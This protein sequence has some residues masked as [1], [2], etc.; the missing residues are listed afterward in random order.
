MHNAITQ[1][2][3]SLPKT[4]RPSQPSTERARVGPHLPERLRRAGRGPRPRALD[5]SRLVL[6]TRRRSQRRWRPEPSQRRRCNQT[7]IARGRGSLQAPRSPLPPAAVRGVAA[8]ISEP[9]GVPGG[10]SREEPEPVPAPGE[11]RPRRRAA[12]G[13]SVAAASQ[14]CLVTQTFLSSLSHQKKFYYFKMSNKIYL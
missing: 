1:T 3:K 9:T 6:Q 4:R 10:E 8:W 11:W 5:T 12:R 14:P 13:R 7:I 2:L